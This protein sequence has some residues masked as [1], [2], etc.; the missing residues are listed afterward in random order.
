MDR[1]IPEL[2]RTDKVTTRS[3]L[4]LIR[5]R[6]GKVCFEGYIVRKEDLKRASEEVYKQDE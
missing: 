4:L 6:P 1:R 3:L 2:N 5:D